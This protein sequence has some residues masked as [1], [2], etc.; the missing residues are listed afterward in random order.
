MAPI[1]NIKELADLAGVTP[2]TV[3]RALADS[4]LISTKTRERI[5]ALALAHDFKPNAMARNLRFRKTG[6]IGVVIPLDHENGQH[7]SDPFFMTMLG[8]LADALAER[9][10]NLL[11]S[12]VMPSN[13]NWLDRF[14]DS[15]RVDGVIV[16]GQS[17]QSDVLD[18]VAA[19]YR[20]LVVWGGHS[21]GQVHCSVGSDN[22]LGGDMAASHLIEC[23]CTSLA[24]LG[25]PRPLEIGQRLE[26]CRDAMARAGLVDKLTILPARLAA[27]AARP[28]SA[29]FFA[30]GGVMPQGVVAASDAVAMATLSVLSEIGLSVPHDVRVIGFDGLA[31]SEITVP[32]LSTIRQDLNAGAAHLVDLLLRRIAGEE[33]GPVIMR[34]ELV[35]RM[36]T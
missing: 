20:P 12:R 19:K 29:N 30:P 24:F 26:G 10:Y 21:H 4:R 27:E 28:D 5:Q 6:A 7:I 1:R 17:D 31:I 2:A 34:P 14:I 16:I 11:L 36:S 22:R 18:Q 35:V 32:R 9:G 25:D 3:S 8:L 23:G 33:P 13:P 15:G